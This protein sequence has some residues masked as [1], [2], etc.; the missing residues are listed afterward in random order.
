M[1]N[2]A[3]HVYDSQLSNQATY[4][5]IRDGCVSMAENVFLFN[6]L[7]EMTS[8]KIINK[9]LLRDGSIAFFKDEILG[10]LAL[11]WSNMG[12]I[13]DV[14]GEPNKIKVTAENG[15][16][17]ILNKDEFVIMYDNLSGNSIYMGVCQYAQRLSFNVRVADINI[18]QQRTPRIWKTSQDKKVSM[19]NLLKNIDANVD[20]VLA[21]N[22][23]DCVIAPAP[24]V[25]DKIDAHY[26]K[27]WNEFLQYIGVSSLTV[28]KKERNIK[29]EIKASLRR[30]YC[31]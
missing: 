25:A 15:Y 3:Y 23:I 28:Q 7:P 29:D 8:K 11:P 4:I 2:T 6:N 20:K 17:R 12:G 26:E 5:M 9:K 18:A 16:T 10:L 21:Y 22:D 27:I 14:N 30:K 24:F 1:G 19:E 31:K 13:L